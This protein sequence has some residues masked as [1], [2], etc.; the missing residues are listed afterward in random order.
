MLM[1]EDA[2]HAIQVQRRG[3]G[4]DTLLR[5]AASRPQAI[6]STGSD[7]PL[8]QIPL[9]TNS[10]SDAYPLSLIRLDGLGGAGAPAWALRGHGR[11]ASVWWV[12]S[13]LVSG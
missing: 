2:T 13:A 9:D 1:T 7:R 4:I 8:L 6:A 5:L 12:P 11:V 10:D 3:Y